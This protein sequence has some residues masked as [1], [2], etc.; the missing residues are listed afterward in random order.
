MEFETLVAKRRSIR[1][2]TQKPV[3]DE[4][5][6]LIL[7]SAL[8]SPTGKNT[9]SWHFVVVKEHEMLAG[10]SRCRAMGSQFLADVQVAIVVMG[11]IRVTDTWVEDASIAAVSM[12][13]QATDLGLGSCWCQVRNRI[14]ASGESAQDYLRT[15]LGIESHHELL[16]VIGIGHPAIERQPQNE[17]S[18]RWNAVKVLKK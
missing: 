7:R 16:C 2:F 15:L 3:S 8:M 17:D 12:Q 1:S 9:R 6:R 5:L 4:D 18:L 14:T 13:Y 11:D 10:M